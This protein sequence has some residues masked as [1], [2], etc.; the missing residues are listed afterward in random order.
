[1][2]STTHGKKDDAFEGMF[3]L[4]LVL[5][6]GRKLMLIIVLNLYTYTYIC[7]CVYVYVYIHSVLKFS[8]EN[9][10]GLIKK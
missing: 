8:A 3:P 5:D 9:Y 4:K 7:V 10:Y 1:M 2:I 6:L